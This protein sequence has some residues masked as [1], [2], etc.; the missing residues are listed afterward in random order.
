M[1]TYCDEKF[2]CLLAGSYTVWTNFVYSH[3]KCLSSRL[4]KNGNSASRVLNAI[5]QQLV[6]KLDS[7][8]VEFNAVLKLHGS[9]KLGSVRHGE[10]SESLKPKIS[11]QYMKYFVKTIWF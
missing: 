2:L 10:I 5:P 7:V 11:T 1:Q 9:C 4:V 8:T 3:F 6:Q